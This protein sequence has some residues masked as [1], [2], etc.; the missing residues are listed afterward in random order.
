MRTIIVVLLS[1]LLLTACIP[2]A[3]LVPTTPVQ[4]T[5]TSATAP[6]TTAVPPTATATPAPEWGIAFAALDPGVLSGGPS[7]PMTFYLVG[8]DGSNLRQITNDIEDIV[9]ITLS[10]DNHELLFGACLEDT[11]NDG[12]A[13]AF[14]LPHLYRINIQSGEIFTITSGNT[15]M[16]WAPSWSPDGKQIAFASAEVNAPNYMDV[17]EF[18]TYLYVINRDGSNKTRITQ[19]EGDI[20]SVIWSPVEKQI[21]FTQ[22]NAIWLVNS[23]GSELFRV[24]D[25]MMSDYGP[26]T[27]QP[28]WSPDGHWIAFVKSGVGEEDNPDV[29]IIKPDGSEVFNLTNHMSEDFQPAWAPDGNHI[30]F[31]S[32]REGNWG[33][34][35]TSVNDRDNV[36]EISYSSAGNALQPV[37]SKDGSQIIFVAEKREVMKGYLYIRD[38]ET[39]NVSQL[40]NFIVGDRPVWVALPL[41]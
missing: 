30:A 33:I 19:Q 10:P 32:G 3:T 18:H 16:E 27:T 21:L 26:H 31:V 41:R 6:A 15:T 34:Y 28:T 2:A 17:T 8:S 7:R 25:T 22:N 1:L 40:S 38:I 12:A 23:D 24:T 14:D 11:N 13:G 5:A 20:R 9:G 36:Q 35:V 4:E 39:T 29:Y 37:W